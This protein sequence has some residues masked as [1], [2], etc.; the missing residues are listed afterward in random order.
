MIHKTKGIVIRV[1]K[2]GETSVIVSI[3]TELFGIQSYIVNGVRT[4][5]KKASGKASQFQPAAILDL[6]VYHNELKKYP[7]PQGIQMGISL[8]NALLRRNQKLSG[9]VHD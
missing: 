2:Y 1:V 8:Q 9:T 6:V 5:S 4:S 7:A 3:Y